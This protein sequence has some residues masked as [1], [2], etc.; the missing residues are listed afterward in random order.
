ME[1]NF[2]EIAYSL[3]RQFGQEGIY[4]GKLLYNF[5]DNHDVNRLASNLTNPAHLYTTYCLLF[6]MPGIP[7]IYYGSEWGIEGIRTDKDDSALRPHLLLTQAKESAPQPNLPNIIGHLA[8]LRLLSPALLY[9]DYAQ[10][11]VSHEQFAFARFLDDEY[12]IV[13]I[14]ASE[15]KTTIEFDIP[16]KN[17]EK[18]NDLLN[19]NKSVT[20]VNEKIKVEVNPHWAVILQRN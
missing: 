10:L 5:V 7:S 20:V 6:T 3:S 12:A 9:G 19:A 17:G 13:A 4:R 11:Y 18:L 14:N 15:E 16:L 2:F 1:K 8:Q